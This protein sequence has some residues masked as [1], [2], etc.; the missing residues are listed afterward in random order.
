MK[1][2]IIFGAGGHVLTRIQ[3]VLDDGWEIVCLC[4]T[5]LNE[6]KLFGYDVVKKS[7]AIDICLKDSDVKIVIG[8]WKSEIIAK[9]MQDIYKE[10]PDNIEIVWN[11][12]LL[13]IERRMKNLSERL[14]I[15]DKFATE[16]PNTLSHLPRKLENDAID[17]KKPKRKDDFVGINLAYTLLKERV[18]VAYTIWK[19]LFENGT[20]SYASDPQNNLVVDES[21]HA[22]EFDDFLKLY[23]DADD[24][25]WDIGC[26]PERMATYLKNFNE[27]HIFGI[28]PL[29]PVEQHP[30]EFTQAIAEFI[31]YEDEQFDTVIYATSL[32]HVLLLDKALEETKRVLKSNGCLLIWAGMTKDGKYYNPYAAD[33]KAIDKYHMFHISPGWFEDYMMKD[34]TKVGFFLSRNSLFYAYK[35]R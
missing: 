27:D 34:W 15:L 19:E 35:K 20:R 4:D 32:N 13:D 26:G 2:C 22:H 17:K 30:F 3:Q 14:E 24:Y 33:V 29:P 11:Y 28:D 21:I 16:L 25:I 10:F 6:R 8:A 18:P 23:V 5:N 12:W 31:P 9:I 1:K 7:Q